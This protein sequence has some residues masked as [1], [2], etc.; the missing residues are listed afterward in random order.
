MSKYFS[1]F[2]PSNLYLKALLLRIAIFLIGLTI[3]FSDIFAAQPDTCISSDRPYFTPPL[4][5]YTARDYNAHTQVYCADWM[6]EYRKWAMGVGSKVLLFDGAD[7]EDINVGEGKPV[8]SMDAQ[9]DTL[10]T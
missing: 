7:F 5:S 6:E 8:Y 9:G 3:V 4:R 10:W 2:T 1:F